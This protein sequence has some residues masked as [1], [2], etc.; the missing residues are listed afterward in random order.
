V[1]KAQREGV[2]VIV[3]GA[4]TAIRRALNTHGVDSPLVTFEPTVEA[5]IA[6]A[7]DSGVLARAKISV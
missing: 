3:S 7:R 1:R 2:A 6:A 4:S 5:A